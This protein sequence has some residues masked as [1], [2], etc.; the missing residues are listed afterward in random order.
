[1]NRASSGSAPSPRPGGATG[2]PPPA[3]PPP[4]EKRQTPRG[5]AGGGAAARRP[6]PSEERRAVGVVPVQVPKKN[7]SVVRFSVEERR[8]VADARTGIEHQSG[9]LLPAAEGE[10]GRVPAVADVRRTRRRR[11][12]AD[13]TECQP[14]PHN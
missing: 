1:M 5:G 8:D 2:T 11:G 14:H 7:R 9:R 10:A 13:P 6:P 12:A 4:T 3:P